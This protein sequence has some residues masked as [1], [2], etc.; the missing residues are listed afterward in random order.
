MT[1]TAFTGNKIINEVYCEE[2]TRGLPVSPPA[3]S[4]CREKAKTL[5]QMHSFSLSLQLC[6]WKMDHS[7]RSLLHLEITGYFPSRCYCWM[8][9]FGHVEHWLH[10]MGVWIFYAS[11][12]SGDWLTF[13]PQ[14]NYIHYTKDRLIFFFF[15]FPNDYFNDI[16]VNL[17]IYF[18]HE[19]LMHLR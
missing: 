7:S 8:K 12:N 10:P 13:L 19:L 6:L 4:P 5:V 16:L 15:N 11:L 14:A 1:G 3:E 18:V 2:M 17:I 9:S